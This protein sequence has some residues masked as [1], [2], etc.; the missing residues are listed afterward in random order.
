MNDD[1]E[2]DQEKI[3]VYSDDKWTNII[4]V[5]N[6][7]TINCW[8]EDS[9]KKLCELIK[10][11]K[12]DEIEEYMKDTYSSLDIFKNNPLTCAAK[13]NRLDVCRLLL[14]RGSDVNVHF[15]S[16]DSPFIASCNPN[17]C[18]E[19][20]ELFLN[21]GGRVN[22]SFGS[23]EETPL[24]FIVKNGGKSWQMKNIDEQ[25]QKLEL[26]LQEGAD[27]SVEA[28]N[29]TVLHYFNPDIEEETDQEV[30]VEMLKLLVDHGS[31][32]QKEDYKG[33]Y[34]NAEESVLSYVRKKYNSSLVNVVV[35]L[36]P[37]ISLMYL[38]LINFAL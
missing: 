22:S 27:A 6:S 2:E 37:Q 23:W 9:I 32:L 31:D 1:I 15:K 13:A 19:I 18:F 4:K 8:T 16:D 21:G 12:F 33:M 30:V 38:G 25:K 17:V 3:D 24:I 26:I 5:I 34:N 36:D 29:R 10:N 11:A 28:C 20:F 35:H 7:W 14:R